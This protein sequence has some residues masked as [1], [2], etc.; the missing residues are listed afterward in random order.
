MSAD[1]D[2]VHIHMPFPLADLA[3]LLSGYKGKVILWWHSDIV[4]QK[5]FMPLYKPLMNWLLRRA[6]RIIV[7]TQ[8]HVRGSNYLVPFSE[9]CVVIPFAAD[10]QLLKDAKN[11]LAT[12]QDPAFPKH[13]FQ[14]LFIGRL[15]GY[16]GCDVLLDAFARLPQGHLT[17][18]GDG[19]MR[20]LLIEQARQLKI[21]DR[22]TFLKTLNEKEKYQIY[23]DCDVFVL[24]SV[25]KNEAFG[26]VQ[27]EAMAYGKP[28]INTQLDSGV[29]EVS[30][31]NVTGL[32]V[33]PGDPVQ[34][35]EAMEQLMKN[36]L[37]YNVFSAAATIRAFSF[38]KNFSNHLYS[39]YATL[40]T[41]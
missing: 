18:A 3:C 32:T 39:V 14:F 2:I 19:P 1:S 9:K 40:N 25:S 27:L 15:V 8:G 13:P 26:L 33:P 36:P 35:A 22:V 34:L 38:S 23:R 30:L 7:A 11:Y 29:P 10:A 16:K 5:A 6:N 37:S 31:H 17:I 21:P 4:R 41:F 20:N 12:K 24:P 28:V